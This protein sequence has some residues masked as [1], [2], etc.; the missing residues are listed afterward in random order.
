ME[1]WLGAHIHAFEYF[2][3][4]PE[5]V[6]PDNLRTGV[7]RA[8]RYDPDLNPTYQEMAMHYGVGVLP[9]RPAQAARKAKVEVGVQVAERWIVAA[10]R[11]R[12]FFFGR[13]QRS[14]SRAAG[15]LN[16]RPFQKREGTRAS[17]FQRWNATRCEPLPGNVRAERV[18]A[19]R[20]NI[21]YH[22]DFDGNFYSVPY[23]W[24]RKWWRSAPRHD[25]GDF[26]SRPARGFACSQFRRGHA[27]HQT[28]ASTQ[29]SPGSPGV[30]AFP[31]DA[32][33]RA[34]RAAH[35]ASYLSKSW[36]RSHI[37]RWA[38]ARAWASSDWRNS[39]RPARME[40]AAERAADRRLPLPER[41]IDPE[42]L[43]RSTTTRQPPAAPPSAS[44]RQ[45]SWR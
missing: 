1:A 7:N 33:G 25:D 26:P 30:A 10:L 13:T 39:I 32:L 18:V 19:A 11:H 34:D 37:R 42:E 4:V 8:C 24:C 21:D 17:V 14:H 31:H 22:I 44:T 43:A 5:L 23:S 29:E 9:A 3:G 20:V 40:A 45:H 41:E 12:K 16:Q 35:G 2:R 38:I 36:P 15:E 28:R 27:D 6:V